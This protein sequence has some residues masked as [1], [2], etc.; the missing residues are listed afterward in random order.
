MFTLAHNCDQWRVCVLG[1]G[2][3][4]IQISVKFA[5][6]CPTGVAQCTNQREIWHFTL[7]SWQTQNGITETLNFTNWGHILWS[8]DQ[9][10]QNFTLEAKAS[11]PVYGAY[12]T[13]CFPSF[14]SFLLS[15]DNLAVAKT[16]WAW[17]W[18]QCS[19][20]LKSSLL[21]RHRATILFWF[22]I[23][24]NLYLV[25]TTPVYCFVERLSS[26]Y[27]TN[28]SNEKLLKYHLNVGNKV[29]L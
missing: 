7:D 23:N 16:A 29:S 22:L 19:L 26:V 4:K 10:I 3:H 20:S 9:L 15:L 14:S 12:H 28:I 13:A 2:P 18:L 24:T 25:K 6:S 17:G 8:F 21:L 27:R 1:L 11:R 5:I